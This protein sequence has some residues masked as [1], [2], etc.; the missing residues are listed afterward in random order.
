[1]L[2]KAL[3]FGLGVFLLGAGVTGCERDLP[4]SKI[5]QTV[6][7]GVVYPFTGPNAATGQDLKAGVELAA[8]IINGTFTLGLPLAQEK[9]LPSHD[10]VELEIIFRDSQSDPQ[11]AGEQVEQ[12]VNKEQVAALM[13]CYSSTVTAAASERAEMMRIPFLNATSTS[14]ILTERDFEWFFRTTPNDRMFAENFFAFL[15]DLSQRPDVNVPKRLILIYENRLW[16]TSVARVERKQALK[17]GYRIVA[18]V[19]YDSRK[20]DFTEHVSLIKNSLPVIILQA[21]Y[22]S[23]AVRFM[24]AYKAQQVNPDAILAMNAGFISPH[25]LQTLGS[26][27]EYIFSRDVWA[28]DL[29]SKKPLVKRV[30]DLFIERYAQ[31]MTGNSARSFT[32][33]ITLAAAIDRAESLQPESIRRGLSEIHLKGEKLIMPWDG[34]CFDS[35]SGQNVLGRGIIVQVQGD[36][37]VTVWPWDLASKTVIWPAPGWSERRE[38]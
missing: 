31:K 8:E 9:G 28:L 3:F 19:P 7:I 4:E 33:L 24:Q 6:K 2:K 5:G 14:P 25:F 21:S 16:G 23:D 27:G 37:Y 11:A 34:I 20:K 13:G 10:N 36:E 38:S 26:D 17:H 32:G 15:K 12:L 1:M 18:E 29:A 35:E 22:A 30:N